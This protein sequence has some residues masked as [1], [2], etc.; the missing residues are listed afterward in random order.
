VSITRLKIWAWWATFDLLLLGFL[1]V[2][3][4]PIIVPERLAACPAPAVRDPKTGWLLCNLWSQWLWLLLRLLIQSFGERGT[5][6]VSGCGCLF[7]LFLCLL[8]CTFPGCIGSHPT[9]HS[10]FTHQGRWLI[11]WLC[12]FNAWGKTYR[13]FI[14]INTHTLGLSCAGAV[15]GTLLLTILILIRGGLVRPR[16]G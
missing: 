8:S 13:I 4:L 15:V 3:R 14:A 1:E 11:Q 9:G 10:R 5:P 16:V 6:W 2:L 12:R 7:G